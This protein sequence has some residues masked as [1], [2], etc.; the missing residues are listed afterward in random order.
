MIVKGQRICSIMLFYLESICSGLSVFCSVLLKTNKKL[1]ETK[2]PKAVGF[3]LLMKNNFITKEIFQK[4]QKPALRKYLDIKSR[5]HTISSKQTVISIGTLLTKG[6]SFWLAEGWLE[7]Q[8]EG[9]ELKYRG[10]G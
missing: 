7:L 4:G 5:H 9:E 10:Y 6:D 2:K 8:I 1:Q 3:L